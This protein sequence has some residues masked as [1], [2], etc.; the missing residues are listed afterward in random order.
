MKPFAEAA[1][2]LSLYP[3]TVLTLVNIAVACTGDPK[4]D[5]RTAVDVTKQ[6]CVLAPIVTG[7]EEVKNICAT[8]DTVA[9]IFTQLLQA[10]NK[11]G[12]GAGD[13]QTCVATPPPGAFVASE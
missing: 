3:L 2:R 7:S 13:A 12:V 5:A 1:I 6:V 8:V 10:Q 11:L 4:T 9:P